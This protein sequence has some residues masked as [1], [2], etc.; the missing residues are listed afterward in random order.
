MYCTCETLG[1][2]FWKL[3]ET[4]TAELFREVSSRGQPHG[5]VSSSFPP[6]PCCYRTDNVVVRLPL[7]DRLP[8]LEGTKH[9]VALWMGLQRKNGNGRAP[10]NMK[11]QN[12]S[13]KAHDAVAC[14]EEQV[15]GSPPQI[16]RHVPRKIF[17]QSICLARISHVY[18]SLP[19]FTSNSPGSSRFSTLSCPL[20]LLT[21]YISGTFSKDSIGP[22]RT[23]PRLRYSRLASR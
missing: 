16:L 13:A 2:K 17:Q 5:N 1:I 21:S 7:D 15:P 18:R 6:K 22:S 14:S 8:F 11:V 19:T 3:T 20:S 10:Q 9:T 4:D 12:I 23:A